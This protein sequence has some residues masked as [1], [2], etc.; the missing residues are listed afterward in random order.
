MTLMIALSYLATG[1]FMSAHAIYFGIVH[2]PRQ[3][4]LTG[5]H[6]A[7]LVV[8]SLVVGLAWV[9]FFPGLLFHAGRALRRVSGG[10]RR[11]AP[12]IPWVART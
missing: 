6:Q 9:F 2:R 1:A 5:N 4:L 7:L 11:W 12:V 10:L 3:V 8:A